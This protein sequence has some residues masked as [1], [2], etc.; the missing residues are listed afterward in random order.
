M[1]CLPPGSDIVVGSDP[2][3]RDFDGPVNELREKH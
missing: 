1:S 2:K 3:V